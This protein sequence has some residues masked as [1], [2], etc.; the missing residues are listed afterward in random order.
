MPSFGRPLSASHPTRQQLDDLDALME[1]MLALP[2]NQAEEL[3]GVPPPKAP[4]APADEALP[5]ERGAA[6]LLAPSSAP[7]SPGSSIPRSESEPALTRQR[8]VQPAAMTQI[9]Q[10]VMLKPDNAESVNA[11]VPLDTRAEI[12]T[13]PIRDSEIVPALIAPHWLRILIWSDRL[14]AACTSWLGPPGRWLRS[15]GGRMA[16]G[17]TGI[18]LLA[19]AAGWV[20]LGT[21]GF[22]W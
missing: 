6:M 3:A 21:W 18:L 19:S 7:A 10:L 20:V 17:V 16:L 9:A 12:I 11:K 22:T 4:R 5:A 1:R 14:F 2:V 13:S 8:I 15:P